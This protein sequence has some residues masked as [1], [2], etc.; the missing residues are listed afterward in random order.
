MSH[1]GSADGRHYKRSPEYIRKFCSNC[2]IAK[3]KMC[4]SC[5]QRNTSRVLA[6]RNS[7]E[8]LRGWKIPNIVIDHSGRPPPAIP[9]PLGDRESLAHH[10]ITSPLAPELSFEDYVDKELLYQEKLLRGNLPEDSSFTYKNIQN[11]DGSEYTQQYDPR[12]SDPQP[13]DRPQYY[14]PGSSCGG[15][16]G[17]T[18]GQGDV[19][20]DSSGHQGKKDK[21]K[22]KDRSHEDRGHKDKS[23][24]SR[25]HK[26]RSHKDTEPANDLQLNPEDEWWYRF[27]GTQWIRVYPQHQDSSGSGS[28]DFPA[29]YTGGSYV[30]NN[31]SE[32]MR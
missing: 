5:S 18:T 15:V 31:F 28:R 13:Y 16:T 14:G 1:K 19:M 25:S 32:R 8:D 10:T 22:G 12:H 3:D 4:H 17:T 30:H 27:D 29:T 21:G 24:K 23:H 20:V 2:D 11:T 26:D 9:H 6:A 7:N